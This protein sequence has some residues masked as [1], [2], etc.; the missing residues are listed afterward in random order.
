MEVIITGRQVELTPKL[1]KHIQAQAKKIEKYTSK[2]T[3]AVFTLKTEK[4]RNIA[5][6]TVTVNGHVLNAQ[7]ETDNIQASLD[8]AM[9]RMEGQLK[10]Q[11]DKL[12]KHHLR[13]GEAH[14]HLHRLLGKSETPRE[15]PKTTASRIK[16]K[17]KQRVELMTLEE[18]ELKLQGLEQGF[19]LFGNR[20]S[21]CLNILYRTADGSLGLVETTYTH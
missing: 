8:L 19:L 21:L 7:E 10:K 13:R 20:K 15:K 6:I 9:D 17:Q 2:A 14:G 5:E 1:K 3:Q 12:A 11:K 4:H 16:K 18:A